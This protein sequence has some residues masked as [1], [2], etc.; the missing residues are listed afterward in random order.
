ML[1]D[2][3]ITLRALKKSDK[4]P[5]AQLLNNKKVCD[6]LRD[7]IPFPYTEQDAVFFINSM[8]DGDPVTI[9][10]IEH[11]HAF[12]G[13]IGVI[14]QKDVYSK[15]AEIGYWLGEPFWNK[16]IITT[17]V[18]LVVDYGFQELG[19]IRLFAGVFE[20]NPASMKV[21]EKNGF[22]KE[23][24]FEKSIFKNGQLWDEHRYARIN[25]MPFSDSV[26]PAVGR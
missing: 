9:F 12:C 5:L 26:L 10:G 19:F 22:K 14:P 6:N 17:A 7:L 21:L 24:V 15:S 2:G 1:T 25:T 13:V 8:K 23:G 3:I 4:T 11:N 20:Y 18:K 16:G